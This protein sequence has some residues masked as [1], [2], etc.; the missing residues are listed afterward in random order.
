MMTTVDADLPCA[1]CGYD[2][3]AQPRDGTCPE[4]GAPVADA[5][6]NPLRVADAKRVEAVRFGLWCAVLAF[7]CLAVDQLIVVGEFCGLNMAG[8]SVDAGWL[9]AAA[10]VAPLL[11]RIRRRAV[12]DAAVVLYLMAVVLRGQAVGYALVSNVWVGWLFR[13]VSLVYVAIA[14]ALLSPRLSREA[15]RWFSWLAVFTAMAVVLEPAIWFAQKIGWWR[16]GPYGWL[17]L[18]YDA[19]R[20]VV[21]LLLALHVVELAQVCRIARLAAFGRW[22]SYGLAGAVGL[23]LVMIYGFGAVYLFWGVSLGGALGVMLRAALGADFFALAAALVA[24]GV[25]AGMLARLSA[26]PRGRGG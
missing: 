19:V 10:G 17:M 15:R 7:A 8:A 18:M 1:R 11:L 4:C 13:N 3:R 5:L 14:V 9:M 26:T 12:R 20:H 21:A 2:L 16:G 22:V 25:Y 24:A 23:W 6:A